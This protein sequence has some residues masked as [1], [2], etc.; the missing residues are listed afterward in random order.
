MR[1][2]LAAMLAALVWQWLIAA[3][4]FGGHWSA[5]FVAGDRFAQSD[6]VKAEGSYV[7]PGSYGYDGQL[8][9]E[10]AHDPL[11]LHA[12]AGF[13]DEPQVRYSRIL[14]PGL[15]YVLGLGRLFWVDRAYRAL[16]LASV[17][18]GVYCVGALAGSSWWGAAFLA[19]PGV[20][21]SLERMLPDLPLAALIAAAL[22]ALERGRLLWCWIALA[23]AALDREMGLIAIAAIAG[24]A[25]WHK[26]FARA[27]GLASAA[28]PAAAW[29][30]YVDLR[31]PSADA[32]MLFTVGLPFSSILKALTHL[33]EYPF[34]P[35]ASAV[36]HTL[37]VLA[38]TGAVAALTAGLWIWRS[39]KS[40]LALLTVCFAVFGILLTGTAIQ[41]ED[42]YSFA[43]TSSPLFLGELLW[44]AR[45]RNPVWVLP[46]AMVLPRSIVPIA[47]MTARALKHL[48]S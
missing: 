1:V 8:Y 40:A 19:L 21:I 24:W 6:P 36:L 5:L 4:Y 44:A 34:G 39:G 27:L 7:L 12:T 17:L 16:E 37:D 43:R 28:A 26:Q 47:S 41:F 45:T 22:L 38:I 3:Q 2:A 11:D 10:I 35:A 29:A 14:V 33:Q 13:L 15:S 18:L 42:V 31:I 20:F 46:L 30:V 48:V 9:H 32:S 23:A 25:A